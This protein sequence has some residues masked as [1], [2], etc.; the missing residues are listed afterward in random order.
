MSVDVEGQAI[1]FTLLFE[2]RLWVCPRAREGQQIG[3][4]KTTNALQPSPSLD[5]WEIS[6]SRSSRPLE[7]P[8]CSSA[9]PGARAGGGA[10]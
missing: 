3:T 4:E 8:G 6:G 9:G 7:R 5:F 2:V 1:A 10:A